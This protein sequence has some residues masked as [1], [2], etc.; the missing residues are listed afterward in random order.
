LEKNFQ[1][2]RSSAGSG[3]TRTLAKEY[4]K[5]ALRFRSDYFKHILAVTF[6]NKSTQ[7]M[8]ERIMR[9]LNDFAN[10][11]PNELAT[12]LQKELGLDTSTF[13]GYA[14][15]VQAEIL[16]NY[17]EFSISTID[18]FFQ[19]II[20]SFTREAGIL[21]D[22][23]LEVENDEVMEQV[24]SNLIGELGESEQLT[25]WVVELALQNLE[26]DRS[27]DMRQSLASFSSEIFREEFK[28]IEGSLNKASQDK[29]FFSET[30]KSL[31][32]KKYSFTNFVKSK[33]QHLLDD[34]HSKG[35]N[36]EDFK[37]S[38]GIHNFLEKFSD[39]SLVKDFN[40]KE[41]GSRVDNEFQS[42][43][44]W[45]SKDH[46]RSK[47][48]IS[49]AEGSWID[50]LNEILNFRKK[51]FEIALTAE[52]AL[53]NFYA[54]GL[55]TDISRKLNEYKKENNIMLLADAPQFLN[56][57]IDNSDTPFIY[58]K[59]GSFYKNFLIDEFQDTSGLQW[60]NFQPLLINSLDSGYRS[61]IVGDVKQ[62]VYRWRGGNQNL[63]LNAN[64]TIGYERTE[65][66]L[67][68]KNFRSSKEIISFN[69]ELFKTASSIV[70][71]EIGLGVSLQ[72]YSDVEQM[73]TQH[74]NGYV[75][76]KFVE[77]DS[78]L[79]WTD[80][81]LEQMTIH[82]E[83]LQSKGVRPTDIALLVR[84]NEEGEKIISHLLSHKSSSLAKSNCVYDVVSSESLRIDSAASVN[85]IVA[86][87]TYLLNPMDD[88]AR[89]QLAYEYSRQQNLEK[90]LSDVF[91]SA[92]PAIFEN[93][94]PL[95][96]SRRKG[97]LKKLPLFEMTETLIEIFE[98]KKT[99]GELP[100]LLAFQDLVLDFAH[101]ERNNLGAFLIWWLENKYK[102][103][104]VA[105]AS[106]NAIQLFT[107]HKAKG[108][109]FK[110]II[111][112]FCAWSLDHEA[113][114]APNLWVK[115]DESVFKNIGYIPVKY[116]GTLKESL[117]AEDYD[118]EHTR[119]LLD[120]FNLLYVA[121]T[122]A[123]TGML[124]IAPDQSVPRIYKTSI[125][126][127]V[128]ES[129][130]RSAT[131]SSSWNKTNKAWVKGQIETEGK[132]ES[133]ELQTA[134]LENYNTSSWRTKLV[135][136]HTSHLSEHSGD[137]HRKKINFGIHLHAAFSRVIHSEDIP[138][139]IDQLES[140]G[141]IHQ[142]EKE[143]LINQI[144]KLMSNPLIAD[145]FSDKWEVRNEAHSLLP[146]GTEYRIDRLLL[147]EK[148]AIVIDFK[149]GKP[150]K[151][152]QNQIGE[153]CNMLNQMGY[154]S[155]G[156]LLYLT[157]GE[158]VNVIPPSVSKKK[159]NKNQLG[160]DF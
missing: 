122:R 140:E 14:R 57:I 7:E 98:L 126:R 123:E 114:R 49:M 109:Q 60:K 67:L 117:F 110:H 12:E 148:Q 11:E 146:K 153:Y 8:K 90:P 82:I 31:R 16:H 52:I 26:N 151:E 2:Y 37:Y 62:A 75:S 24:I 17:N 78:Q 131:L 125:A 55:L 119:I 6:T 91:A 105:P 121:F 112:P 152:D 120:N 44:N 69:N 135:V 71:S 22:Y 115:S 111:I 19:K 50:Q 145:W 87:L 93:S 144:E 51:N 34:I 65:T 64:E 38:G 27:W 156:Y 76:V 124:V 143:N 32:E 66:K 138:K 85:L 130:E 74:E 25:K 83:E 159:K 94:L 107:V 9:Y 40:D 118:I 41:K 77:E 80:R 86:A 106:A 160:L 136:K 47:E 73:A 127:L 137:E 28:A 139:A 89:A 104:I 21:G 132:S 45:P 101:R 92:N 158:I 59:A 29:N 15:E 84:K 46:P 43:K 42:G 99:Y 1:I 128:Y 54:F 133:S 147:K 39:L 5:L 157:E 10:G 142:Q 68:N 154:S 100:Y 63:L 35:L 103:S 61:L 18:A 96:F 4:L 88:I 70:S 81:A 36:A 134:S 116:S 129:I 102:K 30:L 56:S 113:M 3:K 13:Q 97:F 155:E 150:R 58:E 108:L 149:T 23:R 95:E 20:R 79:R 72:E 33:V 48:I 141:I 53:N